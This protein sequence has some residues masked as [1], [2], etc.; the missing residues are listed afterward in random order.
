[1]TAPPGKIESAA[2]AWALPGPAGRVIRRARYAET[3]L[4]GCGT[5]FQRP[6]GA[7]DAA[8]LGCE[9]ARAQAAAGIG[10]D[11]PGLL[12]WTGWN[13]GLGAGGPGRAAR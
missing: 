9:M 7:T 1:M 12:Q 4:C 3:V 11:D 6:R 8:C 10:A 2:A 5:A 13:G